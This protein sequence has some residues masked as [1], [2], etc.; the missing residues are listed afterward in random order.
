MESPSTAA[1]GIVRPPSQTSWSLDRPTVIPGLQQ[2]KAERTLTAGRALGP[3]ARSGGAV[4]VAPLGLR[5]VAVGDLDEH[6]VALAPAAR[7][8]LR[9]GQAAVA[10]AGAAS[11]EGGGRL[12]LGDVPGQQ[13]VQEGLE[14][15]VEGLEL[16]VAPGVVHYAL[17]LA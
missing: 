5:D 4:A 6:V 3:T 2:V 1:S 16:P 15:L 13:V 14:A 10:P 8:V 17:I 7:E 12:C 9:D 11:G